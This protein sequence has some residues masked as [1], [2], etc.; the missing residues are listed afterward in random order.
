MLRSIKSHESTAPA[1]NPWLTLL[2]VVAIAVACALPGFWFD[3][4]PLLLETLGAIVSVTVFAIYTSIYGGSRAVYLR[5][6]FPTFL[7]LA[8]PWLI[9]ATKFFAAVNVSMPSILITPVTFAALLTA[10]AIGVSEE[11]LFRGILFRAFQGKSMTLYVFVASIT[12]GLLHYT[13]GYQ[14]VIG[15]TIVGS[16]YC[17]ARLAGTPLVLLIVCHAA[18][19]FP[20]L[21]SHTPQPPK[22]L[23][24]SGMFVLG[25]AIIAVAF[26]TRRTN[27]VTK[28][29]E[30]QSD[31]STKSSQLSVRAFGGIW[32][33]LATAVF[34]L[35]TNSMVLSET[36]YLIHIIVGSAGL[37][38]GV[39]ALF[40]RPWAAFGMLILS[41]LFAAYIFGSAALLLL[42]PFV[43]GVE[44]IFYPAFICYSLVAGLMGVF[45]VMMAQGLRAHL[46]GISEV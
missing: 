3:C 39:G 33:F 27:W 45:F 35:S 44:D 17:L 6:G 10:L 32:I 22:W 2:L 29:E 38:F 19:N 9:P 4:N 26:F 15:A 21:L 40:S 41:W 1:P 36:T 43:T 24:V 23:A 5:R 13:N 8:V 14:Y 18:H 16:L 31:S 20:D 25:S 46:K 28:F 7:M 42:W 11:V 30:L 37:V 12:F 34:V